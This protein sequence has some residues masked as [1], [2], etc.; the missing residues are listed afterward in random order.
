V[1]QLAE[2]LSEPRLLVHNTAVLTL[3]SPP[4]SIT[5]PRGFLVAMVA[6]IWGAVPPQLPGVQPSGR[7]P[8]YP[9]VRVAYKELTCYPSPQVAPKYLQMALLRIASWVGCALGI[10]RMCFAESLTCQGQRGRQGAVLIND[11][12]D[13]R[14]SSRT[15][16]RAHLT[17]E[18]SSR[19]NSA[20]QTR[21]CPENAPNWTAGKVGQWDSSRIGRHAYSS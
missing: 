16:P 21:Q 13:L 12:S 14:G 11:D 17:N 3:K 2:P 20:D 18:M 8:S 9:M 7:A 5:I 6:L 15:L 10:L 19:T 4:T 1:G